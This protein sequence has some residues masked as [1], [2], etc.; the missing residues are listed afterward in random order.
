MP[1]TAKMI[2]DVDHPTNGL[3]PDSTTANPTTNAKGTAGAY[4]GSASATALP[5]DR[6]IYC[7]GLH[8]LTITCNNRVV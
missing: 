3:I 1:L 2:Q 5:D 4:K 8:D 7:S 6:P